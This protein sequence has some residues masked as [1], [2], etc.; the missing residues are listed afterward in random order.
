MILLGVHLG[1][2]IKLVGSFLIGG[3]AMSELEKQYHTK[4][5]EQ[6]KLYI[7]DRDNG[8]CQ[9]CGKLITT[10]FIIHHKHLATLGNFYDPANLELLCIECHNYVTFVEGINKND[11]GNVTP[12]LHENTDLVEFY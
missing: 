3:I 7:L 5:W 9:R 2:I 4:R 1:L 8:I 12:R 6:M 10:R 11:K